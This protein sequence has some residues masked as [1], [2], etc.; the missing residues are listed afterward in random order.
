MASRGENHPSATESNTAAAP[1]NLNTATVSE[2][3]QITGVGAKKAQKIIDYR[4]EHGEF[5]KVDDL[6]QIPGFGAKTVANLRDQLTT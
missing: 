1:V 2:L 3:Q 6:T 5:K 4:T